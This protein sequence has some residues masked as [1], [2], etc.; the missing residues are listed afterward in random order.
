M[1]K[2]PIFFDP[3]G[4]RA[5]HISRLG[6]LAGVVSTLFV[7]AFAASLLIG[8]SMTG[9]KLGGRGKGLHSVAAVPAL[10]KPAA[11]LAAEVLARQK[12]LHAHRVRN[13]RSNPSKLRPPALAKPAGRALAIGFYVN[14]DDGSYAS[15]KRALPTLDW[16]IPTWMSLSGPEMALKTSVDAKA[17]DLIRRVKPS[18]P[19]L[20]LL[21]NAADSVWDGPGLAR[22]LADPAMRQARIAQIVAFLAANKFQGLTVDFEEVPESAQKNLQAFLSE[23]SD[24]FA[25]HGWAIVLSVPFDDATW[26][27][28]AY[29]DIVD[30]ELL[31]AYDEHWA[32]KDPGSIAGE[33]WFEDTLDKRMK[34]LDPDQT[35]IA[36]GSYGYDW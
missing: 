22:L 14:W 29:A 34:V 21:Q 5:S 23:L 7:V 2:K 31:M 28:A 26:D 15:L 10:L 1:Q 30:F 33:T 24:A 8:P 32:G 27:Y 19:I 18:T 6:L 17:F 13:P 12:L 9:L 36:I 35:I 3:T 25:P 16:V 11:R 20:P 4:R